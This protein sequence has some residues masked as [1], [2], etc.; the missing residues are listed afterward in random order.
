VLGL[1][2][3]I[4][5]F[6]QAHYRASIE[7]DPMLSPLFKD[8]FL[9]HWKEESQHEILDEL[10]WVREDARLD[11]AARDA[12][13]DDL[14]ALVGAVDA[15]LQ[16]QADAD[17]G[18]FLE[19]L[20]R[21]L[22]PDEAADVRATFLSAYRWQYIGSGVREPRFTAVLGSLVTPEQGARISAALAPIVG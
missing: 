17:A 21:P 5:L 13:V 7:P 4:E 16:G 14:I 19:N 12:A 18:Y 9:F 2:C 6:T 22:S 8:V 1:T 15:M 20:G 3:H 11:P 10:E